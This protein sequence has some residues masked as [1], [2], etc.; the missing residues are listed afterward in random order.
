MAFETALDQAVAEIE[1]RL[2]VIERKLDLALEAGGDGDSSA[3]GAPLEAARRTARL[4]SWTALA[5]SLVG[6]LALATVLYLLAR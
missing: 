2:D 5:A 6:L 3:A 4:A 1:D